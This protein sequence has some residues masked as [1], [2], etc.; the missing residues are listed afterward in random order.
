MIIAAKGHVSGIF[1][2]E[3]GHEKSTFRVGKPPVKIRSEHL[4]QHCHYLPLGVAGQRFW[5]HRP[6]PHCNLRRLAERSL[7][8]Q[9]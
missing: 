2:G 8:I 1:W 5:S 3:I 9:A 6:W 4:T 7:E